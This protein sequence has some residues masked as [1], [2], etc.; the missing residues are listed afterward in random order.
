MYRH[1][2]LVVVGVMSSVRVLWQ[3]LHGMWLS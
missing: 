2:S 1:S 3:C